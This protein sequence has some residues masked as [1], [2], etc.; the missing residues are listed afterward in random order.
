MKEE[1]I[2]YDAL[3]CGTKNSATPMMHFSKAGVI[4]FNSG[5]ANS[6]GLKSGDMIKL[7][8]MQR[9]PKE[10]FFAK[11]EKGGFLLRKAY[12]KASK[13]LMVN[14]AFTVGSIMKALNVNKSFKVQIGS[15][16]DE[17]GWWSL[18]TSGVK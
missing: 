18:I 10:W 6:I 9:N 16:P 8:Q 15:E 5:A 12:D 11:V 2:T 17:D 3:S 7:F 14:N 4:S 1:F 13:G